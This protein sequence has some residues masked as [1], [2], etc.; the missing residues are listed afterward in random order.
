MSASEKLRALEQRVNSEP[1]LA[2][3]ERYRA[4]FPEI[5]EVVKAAESVTSADW[6]AWHGSRLL[7]SL[8]AL[9][10]ALR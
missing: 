5:V 4:A 1:D 9:E 8:A 3:W 6:G 10:E 7:L 2:S